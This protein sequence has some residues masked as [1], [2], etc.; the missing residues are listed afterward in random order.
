MRC[1]VTRTRAIAAPGQVRVVAG[2]VRGCG[3]RPGRVLG[4]AAAGASVAGVGLRRLPVGVVSVCG[5]AAPG[6][7]QVVAGR[8]R[9]C[10]VVPGRVRGSAAPGVS[11]AG[12]VSACE[13]TA[14]GQA[15]VVASR[16]RGCGVV[17]DRVHGGA[18]PGVFGVVSACGIAAPGQA[19]AAAGRVRGGAAPGASAAD[20][21]ST[22]RVAAPAHGRTGLGSAQ[23]GLENGCRVEVGAAVAGVGKA[24]GR[25]A[26]AERL[27][28]G[29]NLAR[30]GRAVAGE[31]IA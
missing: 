8:V 19:Q 13:I 24:F 6:R 15:R 27:P 5:I 4:G 31:C 2:R 20:V 28:V 21:G 3:V 7:I 11:V 26:E 25:G 10:G 12:V 17:L 16:A 22:A 23:A 1:S 30:V 14:P 18:A 9:G 29:T